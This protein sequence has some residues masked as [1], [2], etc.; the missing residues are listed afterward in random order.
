MNITVGRLKGDEESLR[1]YIEA[2]EKYCEKGISSVQCDQ[3][4]GV[5]EF[6]R[7]GD[8]AWQSK[9]PC[10]KYNDNLRGI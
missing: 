10:N 1:H 8:S 5:I 2:F 9:C 4:Q 3:C 6:I 7:L